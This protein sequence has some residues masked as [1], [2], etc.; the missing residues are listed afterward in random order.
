[1]RGL[2]KGVL[3][4]AVLVGVVYVYTQIAYSEDASSTCPYA[5]QEQRILDE[6][7]AEPDRKFYVLTPHELENLKKHLAGMNGEHELP[8]DKVYVI[9]STRPGVVHVFMLQ[10]GCIW[11]YQPTPEAA[12][13]YLISDDTTGGQP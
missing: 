10:G 8:I 11:Y 12:I 4:A 5:N 9:A 6:L 7:A 2:W 3:L 1:M 13:N